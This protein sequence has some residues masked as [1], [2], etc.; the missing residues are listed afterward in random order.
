MKKEKSLDQSSA[1]SV[2]SPGS[3]SYVDMLRQFF[4]IFKALNAFS[5]L[6]FTLVL[7]NTYAHN[8]MRK[9]K[10]MELTTSYTKPLFW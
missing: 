5:H 2:S 6:V 1:F 3:K 4:F 7:W 8:P 10:L 9:L